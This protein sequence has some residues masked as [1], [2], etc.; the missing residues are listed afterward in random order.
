MTGAWIANADCRGVDPIFW[1]PEIGISRRHAIN[2]C[3]SCPVMWECRVY[4][5]SYRLSHG[6]YWLDGIWGGLTPHDRLN[7]TKC[8]ELLDEALSMIE[9]N[10]ERINV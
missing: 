2:I 4:S 8:R 9:K 5:L 6:E 10:S 7:K 1:F 3:N